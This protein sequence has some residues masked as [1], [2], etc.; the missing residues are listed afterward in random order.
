MPQVV[1]LKFSFLGTGYILCL[2]PT[3][4]GCYVGRHDG[5]IM[6]IGGWDVVAS[7]YEVRVQIN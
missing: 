3:P 2:A 7:E 1:V 6:K 4:T 5:A